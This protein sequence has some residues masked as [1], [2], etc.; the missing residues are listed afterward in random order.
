MSQK[1]PQTFTQSF[2]DQFG[3][4]GTMLVRVFP[5]G[6]VEYIVDNAVRSNPLTGLLTSAIMSLSTNPIL[7]FPANMIRGQNVLN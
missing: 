4:F 2:V 3:S 5:D 1:T 7:T 6:S